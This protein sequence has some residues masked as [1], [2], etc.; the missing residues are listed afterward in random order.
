MFKTIAQIAMLG[1][2]A[3]AQPLSAQ[4]SDIDFDLPASSVD[5]NLDLSGSQ[6]TY[7]PS[8]ADAAQQSLQF[9]LEQG[10][11]AQTAGP[12]ITAV[13]DTAARTPFWTENDFIVIALIAAAALMMRMILVRQRAGKGSDALFVERYR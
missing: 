7:A 9:S 2:F 8:V 12:A 4:S 3:T 5:F 10:A 11:T 1:L 13:Q 6:T